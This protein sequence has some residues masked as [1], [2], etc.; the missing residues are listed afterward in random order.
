MPRTLVVRMA[1]RRSSLQ[2]RH[3]RLVF[4]FQLRSLSDRPLLIPRV[5]QGLGLP[6]Q[7]VQA[8]MPFL[9]LLVEDRVVP[10]LEPPLPLQPEPQVAL[11]FRLGFD[12]QGGKGDLAAQRSNKAF[13]PLIMNGN[14]ARAGGGGVE[15]PC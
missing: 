10:V 13:N 8:G 1:G 5:V 9:Q 4:P 15:N 2:Q 3:Q 11:L 12:D 6:G 14:Q 7:R